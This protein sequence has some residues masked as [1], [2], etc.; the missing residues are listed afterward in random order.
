[1]TEL[2]GLLQLCTSDRSYTT[3]QQLLRG[4]CQLSSSESSWAILEVCQAKSYDKKDGHTAEWFLDV[5]AS[6][7]F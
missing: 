3:K 2:P 1:M 6:Q 4:L 5:K 7:I